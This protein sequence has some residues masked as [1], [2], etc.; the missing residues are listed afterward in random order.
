[1]DRG[2]QK[3]AIVGGGGGRQERVSEGVR[4]LETELCAADRGMGG[5]C[6]PENVM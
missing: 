3:N 1:M 6:G 2:V 5:R 4:K